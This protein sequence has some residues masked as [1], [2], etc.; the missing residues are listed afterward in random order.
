MDAATL[1]FCVQMYKP[2]IK[3]WSIWCC[4][5]SMI[6]FIF[7]RIPLWR[8]KLY[9]SHLVLTLG[10]FGRAQRP[11]VLFGIL[12]AP[13]GPFRC[14]ICARR[15]FLFAS[16]CPSVC[17]SKLPKRLLNTGTKSTKN[18]EKIHRRLRD[19]FRRIRFI[20]TIG[21]NLKCNYMSLKMNENC[22]ILLFS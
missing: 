20:I 14:F 9:A 18:H 19:H 17:V 12:Y 3:T 1:F 22:F 15:P 13:C 6:D 2:K 7:L 21:I 5:Y 11:T 4:Q 16:L 10:L 8:K